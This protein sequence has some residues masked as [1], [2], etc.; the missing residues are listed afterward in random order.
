MALTDAERRAY[1]RGYQVRAAQWPA[2]KPPIPPDPIVGSL[3]KALCELVAA[4]DGELGTFDPQDEL[5]LRMQPVLEAADEALIAVSRW[6]R[7][8][9]AAIRARASRNDGEAGG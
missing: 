4:C 7:D 2:H 5:V 1:S 9:A 6:L 3:V 8:D